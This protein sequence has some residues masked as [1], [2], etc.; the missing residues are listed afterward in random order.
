MVLG[1]PL[2]WLLL[3][4][5]L[6]DR[7]TQPSLTDKRP[8]QNRSRPKKNANKTVFRLH[9]LPIEIEREITLLAACSSPATYRALL[10]TCRSTKSLCRVE[11]TIP[12]LSITLF[13]HYQLESFYTALRTSPEFASHVKHLWVFSD[14]KFGS[15]G[16]PASELTNDVFH[17]C[18][19][20]VSAACNLIRFLRFPWLESVKDL[21]V[22][23]GI[24]H[25]AVGN[26]T[27][28]LSI[29][30][31]HIMLGSGGSVQGTASM[32]IPEIESLR[33]VSF[34]L[35]NIPRFGVRE[36][37]GR[38]ERVAV[39]VRYSGP[40]SEDVI[41]RAV[42]HT[43]GLGDRCTFHSCPRRLG[44]MKLWAERVR[45]KD[46]IWKLRKVPSS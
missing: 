1:N 25:H 13:R 36:I 34:S 16:R 4:L 5:W 24:P 10:L 12:Y 15:D 3:Y 40:G 39:L 31:L 20:I 9:D 38:V 44:E 42:E 28:N 30:R 41:A 19:N 22:P 6:K 29:E 35:G 33:Q 2:F 11:E 7:K 46:A 8:S 26:Q 23:E 18:P 32:Y 43:R 27:S 45:D 14:R 37:D 17:L 21:T